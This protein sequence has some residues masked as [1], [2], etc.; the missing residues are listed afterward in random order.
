[1]LYIS[2][3]FVSSFLLLVDG[4]RVLNVVGHSQHCTINKVTTS[5]VDE[6]CSELAEMMDFRQSII[7]MQNELTQI[8]SE[9]D[10]LKFSLQ[11]TNQDCEGVW[12]PCS[13]FCE[14]A[15]E[16]TFQM[17]QRQ[18]GTG[19]ECPV[20]ADC[21]PG[22]D[23]CLDGSSLEAQE[24]S[25]SAYSKSTIWWVATITIGFLATF[26]VTIVLDAMYQNQLG[27]VNQEGGDPTTRGGMKLPCHFNAYE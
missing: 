14:K 7:D 22:E 13:A 20:A 15:N 19:S 27:R 11:N 25:D 1:M 3:C 23:D 5:S 8:S 12:S 21:Q 4:S 9:I 16:R 10:G 18:L 26:A 24:D 2:F 17:F 6:L